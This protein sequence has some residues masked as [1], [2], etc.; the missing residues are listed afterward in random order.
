M[1]SITSPYFRV[2]LVGPE[3]QKQAG[4]PPLETLR[5]YITGN[6]KSG[7][8]S[9]VAS[10]P[11]ALILDCEN[12]M[13]WVKPSDL[14]AKYVVPT[15]LDDAENVIH[16][17]IAAKGKTE[18]KVVVIDTIDEFLHTFVIPGITKELF[19]DP[20]TGAKLAATIMD[21]TEY[22]SSDKGSGGWNLVYK[23]IGGLLRGLTLAGYG[24]VVTGH[25]KELTVKKN[26]NG[27]FQ[28]VTVRRPALPPG[29]VAILYRLAENICTTG[30]HRGVR[31]DTIERKIGDR[32][33]Q[34]TVSVDIHC[35]C[36]RISQKAGDSDDMPDIGS[37]ITL[38]PE[39]LFPRQGEAWAEIAAAYSKQTTVEKE[40]AN[41]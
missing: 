7:K 6:V 25:T 41:G 36:L 21:V 15:S 34:D 8:T 10:I 39:I 17:L 23:R 3:Q 40:T 37:N 28:D 19:D 1:L 27:R 12:K 4:P 22:K 16:G 38:P 24:W 29:L 33:I 31:T 2:P 18:Y 13:Q 20:K 30:W 5:W 11:N 32:V 14:K 9:L 26:V 35:P